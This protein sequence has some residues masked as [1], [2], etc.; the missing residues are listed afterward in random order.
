VDTVGFSERVWVDNLGM[1][2]TER[3][4]TLEKFTRTDYSTIKYQITV[5]DPGAYTAPW[6]SG[7]YMRWTSPAESFEFVCQD[8]NQAPGLIV[9]DGTFVITSPPYVP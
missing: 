1:P 9:G 5:D 7:F 2:T 3:L 8:N 6:S 4:H